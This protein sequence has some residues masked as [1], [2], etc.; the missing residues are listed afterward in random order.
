M[1]DVIPKETSIVWLRYTKPYSAY[2]DVDL[3]DIDLSEVESV[4]LGNWCHLIIT[5]KDGSVHEKEAHNIQEAS[6][7]DWKRG[8]ELMGFLDEDYEVLRDISTEEE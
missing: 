8:W 2:F 3:S 7:P 6:Q 1:T 4:K 5:M